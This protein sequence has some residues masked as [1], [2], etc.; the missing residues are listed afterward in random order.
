[1]GPFLPG[2]EPPPSLRGPSTATSSTPSG[3]TDILTSYTDDS[4]VAVNLPFPF[5]LQGVDYYT[6]YVGSNG[7]IT[8]GEGYSSYSSLLPSFPSVPK[9]FFGPGD[10]NMTYVG[11]QY[12]SGYGSRANTNL[13]GNT[14]V[15]IR[16][17]T[18]SVYNVNLTRGTADSVIEITFVNPENTVGSFGTGSGR[19]ES[20]IS[21]STGNW[22]NN[23]SNTLYM[24]GIYSAS[25]ELATWG[26]NNFSKSNSQ[27]F[28]T[29]GTNGDFTSS[30]VYPAAAMNPYPIG[31][32]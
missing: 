13:K 11:V 29:G 4:F 23:P 31:S 5:R 17:E 10:R 16:I 27:W 24:W 3:F 32:E 2:T 7:Y 19:N 20:R 15:V 21:I 9:I 14:A 28:V 18:N 30:S 1:M 6:A 25:A 12:H 8:F 22:V 26:G